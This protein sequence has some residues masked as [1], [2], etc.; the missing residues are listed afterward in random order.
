MGKRPAKFVKTLGLLARQLEGT[1]Y[2]IRG[3]A[4]IVLQNIEMN[5]E[6]IDIVTD[7]KTAQK[8]NELLAD[9]VTKEV[10]YSE[11][12]KYKSYFGQFKINDILVEVYGDWQIKNPKGDWSPIFNAADSQRTLV[13]VEDFAI[14]VTRIETELSMFVAMGRWT[15]YHKIKTQLN[16]SDKQNKLF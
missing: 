12:P 2:A 10:S 11:S 5:V 9:F 6:D 7:G 3:T 16:T 1:Q 8:C 4:G 15:A 14:Y 13:T